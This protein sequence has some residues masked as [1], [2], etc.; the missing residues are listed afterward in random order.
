MRGLI[1][2]YNTDLDAQK[3]S[4]IPSRERESLVRFIHVVAL[5]VGRLLDYCG[6]KHHEPT[7]NERGPYPASQ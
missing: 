4:L 5:Q 7:Q 3:S 1:L 2:D 6:N